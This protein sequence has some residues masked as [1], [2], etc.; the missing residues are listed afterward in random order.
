MTSP[1]IRHFQVQFQSKVIIQCV[2]QSGPN[3]S[4]QFQSSRQKLMVQSRS[5][6]SSSI[7]S[8]NP[9]TSPHPISSLLLF[10]LQFQSSNSNPIGKLMVQSRSS[11]LSSSQYP[12][13]EQISSPVLKHPTS[14]HPISSLPLLLL[15]LYPPPIV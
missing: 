6:H 1:S 15:L 10:Q 7:Q 12:S 2:V 11:H 3:V 5:S 13:S 4:I 8:I 14:P 9:P